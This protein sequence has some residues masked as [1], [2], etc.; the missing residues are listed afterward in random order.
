MFRANTVLCRSIQAQKNLKTQGNAAWKTVHRLFVSEG[1]SESAPILLL[2][3]LFLHMSI[4]A[5]CQVM[6]CQPQ[7]IGDV[8]GPDAL[9]LA[10]SNATFTESYAATLQAQVCDLLFAREWNKSGLLLLCNFL[11]IKLEEFVPICQSTNATLTKSHATTLQAQA[12]SGHRY[13]AYR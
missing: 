4:G 12:C 5:Q 1:M 3:V 9:R 11:G 7:V 10:A 2:S 6:N 8:L 13:V